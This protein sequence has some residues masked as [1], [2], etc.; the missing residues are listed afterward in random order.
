MLWNKKKPTQ[1]S[2]RNK[3]FEFF[4]ERE[5]ER[6]QSKNYVSLNEK[7]PKYFIPQKNISHA[8]DIFMF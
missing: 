4:W 6:E 1:P 5:R 3:V 8:N 2:L 7:V